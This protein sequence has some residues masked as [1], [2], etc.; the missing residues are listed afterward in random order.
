V[1]QAMLD[2]AVK[3]MK[4]GA[5][6]LVETVEAGPV[7]EGLYGDALGKIAA[8]HREVSIG[9][10]PSYKDGRFS[11]QIV[12]RGKDEAVVAAALKAVEAML[13]PLQSDGKPL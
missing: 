6:M 3:S 4:T 8:A 5:V 2:F 13:V 11:N 12:V 1:M 10:Y 7:P 9:S